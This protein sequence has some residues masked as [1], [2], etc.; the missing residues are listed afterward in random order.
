MARHDELIQ[1]ICSHQARFIRAA[2]DGQAAAGT[3]AADEEP[4]SPAASEGNREPCVQNE[5]TSLDELLTGHLFYWPWLLV[6][7]YSFPS[8]IIPLFRMKCKL[9]N[10]TSNCNQHCKNFCTVR[11]H[12]NEEEIRG[13]IHEV[14]CSSRRPAG[15]ARCQKPRRRRRSAIK[16]YRSRAA[17]IKSKR[18]AVIGYGSQ[19]LTLHSLNM[20]GLGAE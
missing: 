1:L 15:C 8:E 2:A 11:S 4:F 10:Q 7:A 9:L 12:P 5:T 17:I 19:G 20:K 18:V 13:V 3:D 14:I 6:D 16:R